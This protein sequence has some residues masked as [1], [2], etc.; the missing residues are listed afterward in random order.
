MPQKTIYD[1]LFFPSGLRVRQLKKDA[2]RLS[3]AEGIG[4]SQALDKLAKEN[5]IPMT[6]FMALR[7]LSELPINKERFSGEHLARISQS[8]NA[9]PSMQRKSENFESNITEPKQK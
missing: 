2:R 6:W 5:G 8:W 9:K 1:E 4:H 3:K 7:K